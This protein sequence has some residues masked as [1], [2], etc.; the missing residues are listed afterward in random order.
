MAHTRLFSIITYEFPELKHLS[1][2]EEVKNQINIML[3]NM[4]E[5]FN[6]VKINIKRDKDKF[7]STVN[8]SVSN[9]I[10]LTTLNEKKKEKN[11]LIVQFLN[12]NIMMKE[13]NRIFMDEFKIIYK[14]VNN[15]F[16]DYIHNN[17]KMKTELIQ[18]I[19]IK[20]YKIIRGLYDLD[21]N[22]ED[23]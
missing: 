20:S 10:D 9:A 5:R 3:D 8:K 4:I 22:L 16:Y 21:V 12:N 19:I 6:K 13:E 2:D 1:N 18:N 17:K 7:N 23:F 11:K 14:V 15:I